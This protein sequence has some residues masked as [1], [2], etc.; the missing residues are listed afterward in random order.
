MARHREVL[1]V[2]DSFCSQKMCSVRRVEC[3][4]N[5]VVLHT[6]WTISQPE[7]DPPNLDYSPVMKEGNKAVGCKQATHEDK[8]ISQTSL[9]CVTVSN[10][11]GKIICIAGMSQ[12]F[13]LWSLAI[14]YKAAFVI[15]VD[16]CYFSICILKSLNLTSDKDP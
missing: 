16:S 1:V 2:R 15:E 3:R 8:N 5:F 13:M 9:F 7:L 11:S 6:V 4:P 14:K 10:S 12:P